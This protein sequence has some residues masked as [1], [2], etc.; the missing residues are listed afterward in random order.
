MQQLT[1]HKFQNGFKI[2]KICDP[3][4]EKIILRILSIPYTSLPF[5]GA[6]ANNLPKGT[7]SFVTSVRYSHGN[8]RNSP[9]GFIR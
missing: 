2:T 3:D 6:F 7:I 4:S 5:S 9:D 1:I 8:A